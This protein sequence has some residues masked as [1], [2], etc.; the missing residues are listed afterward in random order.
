MQRVERVEV[1]SS[2]KDC[3]D[4][5][6]D[7]AL[8]LMYEFAS[9]GDVGAIIPV[10]GWPMYAAENWKKFVD[11]NRDLTLVVGD[12]LTVQLDLMNQGYVNGLVGQLPFQMG[13][14]SIDVLMKLVKGEEVNEVIFGTALLEV[15]Q[16][17]LNL[18]DY[19]VNNNYV[20]DLST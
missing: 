11:L 5:V 10:G 19:T 9:E 8:E 2:F 7:T 18:P 20:L 15:I 6:A 16:F 17:P 3:L 1:E 13:A 12:T 4:D 14:M